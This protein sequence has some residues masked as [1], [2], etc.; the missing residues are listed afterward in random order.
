MTT[1]K[2]NLLY[3]TGFMGS[4]KSTIAPILAN[5]LGYTHLD[6]DHDIE[7][8]MGKTISMIFSEHGE[9]FFRDFERS[10]L[11]ESG[12]QEN[13]VVSLGGGTIVNTENLRIVLSHGILIYLKA[14]IQHIFF[15]MRHKTNRPLLR[16]EDG[17]QLSDEELRTRIDTLLAQREPFYSQADITVPTDEQ[18][19]GKTVDAIVKQ[20][21]HFLA[22]KSA[23]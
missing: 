2:H 23:R 8:R 13:C 5:T 11:R 21:K 12:T 1:R 14:D 22:S 17:K 16:T 9:Q 10:T 7:R 6:L 20:L 19:V 4:G 3:L 15:R 18:H